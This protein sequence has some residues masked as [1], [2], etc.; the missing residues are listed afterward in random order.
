MDARSSEKNKK[1]E[2]LFLIFV[3]AVGIEWF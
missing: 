2:S 1:K 3:R